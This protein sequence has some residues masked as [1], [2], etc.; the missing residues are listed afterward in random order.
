MNSAYDFVINDDNEVLLLLY[1]SQSEPSE[2]HF[3][4]KSENRS[5]ELSRNA[6]EVLV[7]DNVPENILELLSAAKKLLV[8]ELKDAPKDEDVEV[9]YVYEAEAVN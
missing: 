1:A 7:L 4:L 9:A 5:V 8:C 2:A 3:R 6:K